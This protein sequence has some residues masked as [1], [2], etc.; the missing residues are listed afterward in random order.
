MMILN[1]T[2]LEQLVAWNCMECGL[3]L[4]K[5]FKSYELRPYR[6]IKCEAQDKSI[7]WVKTFPKKMRSKN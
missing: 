5:Q 4:Y 7:D 2:I 6:N 1:N 3:W